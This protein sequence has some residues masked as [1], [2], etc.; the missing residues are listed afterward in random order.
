MAVFP[1]G[2]VL[3][4]FSAAPY[5]AYAR[6]KLL[7]SL[8]QQKI[9]SFMQRPLVSTNPGIDLHNNHWDTFGNADIRRLIAKAWRW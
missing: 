4:G 9:G 1:L 6:R 2:G 3:R 7:C 8:A 5:T